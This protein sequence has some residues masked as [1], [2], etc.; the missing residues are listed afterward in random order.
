MSY[1]Y[2]VTSRPQA[3]GGGYRLQLLENGEEVG[4]GVF[5]GASFYP[6]QVDAVVTGLLEDDA[7]IEAVEAGEDWLSTR[8]DTDE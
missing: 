5:P 4:G 3:L 1:E 8:P 6:D 7:Y 2:H